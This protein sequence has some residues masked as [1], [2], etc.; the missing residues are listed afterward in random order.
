[1]GEKGIAGTRLSKL[2][3]YEVLSELGKGAMGIV[4][5]AKDPVIGRMVAIKTIRASSMGDDDS[6]SR[7]FRERFIREAQTAG[8]LSHPQHRDDPRHRR[9]PGHPDLVHRD[10]VHRGKEPQV[11]AERARGL[12]LRPDRRDDRAGRRGDRLRPPQGNHPSRHQAGEHHHHDR[13]EGEDH[14]LRDREGRLLEP[15]DDRPVSRHAQLHVSGA[16]LRRAGGRPKRHLLAGRRSLRAADA[17][18]A[19]RRREPDGDLVQDRPRGLHAAGR[20]RE[21][22]ADGVQSDR[23]EGDGERPVESL[24][25]REGLR[26]RA[27]PAARAPRGAASAAGSRHDR[28]PGG[29]P[30]DPEAR[31]HGS[32]RRR[33][34]G[35]PGRRRSECAAAAD[36]RSAAAAARR[37]HSESEGDAAG[38]ARGRCGRCND[39]LLHGRLARRGSRSARHAGIGNSSDLALSRYDADHADARRPRSD[40]R[41]RGGRRGSRRHV[42]V[43]RRGRR[44]PLLPPPNR[45]GAPPAGRRRKRPAGR[46]FLFLRKSAS[47]RSTRARGRSRPSGASGARSSPSSRRV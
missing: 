23:R 4:Y 31:E 34:A 16:G 15:D 42:C 17:P 14:R 33:G 41:G 3:R 43:R 18:Q 8:I 29:I 10:G 5:L 44:P 38:R 22:G 26:A 30:A 46:R 11:A 45:P 35:A 47:P 19:V 36:H 21:R 39:R 1:M 32:A 2:G 25:A 20:A 7:E 12:L 37:S 13:R 9:G 6:E 40:A 24:P 27:P 28:F